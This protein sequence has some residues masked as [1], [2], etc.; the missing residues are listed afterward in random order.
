MRKRALQCQ[1]V[2]S[3]QINHLVLYMHSDVAR[4]SLDRNPTGGFMFVKARIAFS[5]L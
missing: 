1:H 3:R 5:G 2:P 4:D